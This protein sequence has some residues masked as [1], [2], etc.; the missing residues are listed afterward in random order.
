GI[1][2]S[3]SLP[4]VGCVPNVSDTHGSQDHFEDGTN[5]WV[6]VQN[7][8]PKGRQIKHFGVK[9]G[10]IEANPYNDTQCDDT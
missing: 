1:E 7:Q 3:E 10:Q 8:Y 2:I 9:Q 6:V 4:A 5:I